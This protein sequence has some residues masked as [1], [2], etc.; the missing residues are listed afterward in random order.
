M[1]RGNFAVF[2]NF[3]EYGNNNKAFQQYD[4]FNLNLNLF[5]HL[6]NLKILNWSQNMAKIWIRNKLKKKRKIM[7][8]TELHIFKFIFVLDCCQKMCKPKLIEGISDFVIYY[9]F[10]QYGY[11]VN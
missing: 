11:R 4:L 10:L 7:T 2:D 9:G 6:I 8:K 5:F 3:V 1:I